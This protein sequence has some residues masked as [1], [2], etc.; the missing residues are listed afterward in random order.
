[1]EEDIVMCDDNVRGGNEVHAPDD[2][3][4]QG[5]RVRRQLNT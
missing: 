2:L 1:M 5:T 3:F 4:L